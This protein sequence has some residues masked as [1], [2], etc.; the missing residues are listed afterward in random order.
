MQHTD[1]QNEN[2]NSEPFDFTLEVPLF[3]DQRLQQFWHEVRQK[4]KLYQELSE[5]IR[6]KVQKLPTR[7]NK[8]KIISIGECFLDNN[9]LLRFRNRIWIPDFEPLRTSIIQMIHDFY[10]IGYPG[11]NLTYALLSKQFFWPNAARKVKQMLSNCATCRRTTIWRERK[12]GLLKPLP[13][14]ERAFAEISIDFIT[15]LP[16]TKKKSTNCLVVVD[17]LTKA[18]LLQGIGEITAEA[19]ARRLYE[20]FYPYYSIPR[21]ITS[22]RGTQFVSDVWRYFCKLLNIEQRLSTAY[23]P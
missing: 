17:R 20:T 7:I 6:S 22:D 16:M 14:P 18:P 23:H 2:M 19:T 5:A 4:N 11:K 3:E 13:V 9:G 1:E 10:L 12:K 8:Q 21:A 15:D